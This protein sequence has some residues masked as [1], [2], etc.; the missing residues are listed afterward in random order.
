MTLLTEAIANQPDGNTEADITGQA[1]K[2]RRQQACPAQALYC[3]SEVGG[4][5]RSCF[6]E[7]GWGWQVG[8]GDAGREWFYHRGEADCLK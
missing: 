3:L 4:C 1:H 6:W 5:I 8:G 7:V 2:P